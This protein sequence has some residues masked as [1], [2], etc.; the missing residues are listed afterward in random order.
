M[1]SGKRG[2]ATAT[3]SDGA[4][5]LKILHVI[6]SINPV[7]GGP[8]EGVKQLAS[9]L[10]HWGH[11]VEIASLDSPGVSFLKDFPLAVHPLGPSHF[12]Y[13]FSYRMIPWLHENAYHYDAVII[14]GL[15]QYHSFATW[16]A[17]RNTST[18]YVVFTHGMLD[19]W[20]KRTYPFKH[21]KK[22]M[23]WP[24]AEYRVLRDASAVFFTCE[25]ERLLARQSFWLYRCNEIVTKY[26]TAGPTGNPQIQKSAFY[27]KFPKLQDKRLLLFMG[28]VHPKK[29]C[30]LLLKAFARTI[31]ANSDYHLV[32][33][34]PDQVGWQTKLFAQAAQLD[35]A[36]RVTWTGMIAGDLKW[37][38]FHAAEAF[39][40]PSHQ[41]N[42]G[43]VVA[44]AMACGLP[45]LISNKINIWRE[46]QSDRAG[47]VANDD[48]EGTCSL[49][50][51]WLQ[52]SNAEKQTMSRRARICFEERFE[53]T[54]ATESLIA[55]L[56]SIQSRDIS[57]VCQPAPLIH[58]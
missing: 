55:I 22:W 16:R 48:L 58:T 42:F 24:W 19:P 26:G 36:E 28:R 1:C 49:L 51:S 38:A 25:E 41:E 17:L 57:E 30:D 15:W 31:S 5:K 52:M 56:S 54:K 53:I 45:P 35:I 2:R 12:K 10:A 32:M 23:Y 33:A 6:R 46:I 47:I 7:G 39:I 8:I 40:L 44:E 21:L 4:G 9:V 13:G 37:G 27:A 14:N 34:G 43:I 3:D 20:F 50:S 29:G 18:P 11:H